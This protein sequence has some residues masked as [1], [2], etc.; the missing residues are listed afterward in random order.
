MICVSP[1]LVTHAKKT[2]PHYMLAASIWWEI[3]PLEIWNKALACFGVHKSTVQSV[4]ELDWPIAQYSRVSSLNRGDLMVG[5]HFVKQ[6][7]DIWNSSFVWVSL[8][9][10][11]Y[12]QSLSISS[13]VYPAHRSTCSP[14]WEN[15]RLWI[16]G[17]LLPTK[18]YFSCGVTIS[19]MT[20]LR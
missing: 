19:T 11:P 9:F 8:T 13:P 18:P 20:K 17:L 5:H 15:T 7:K 1:L 2:D 6:S 16:T 14:S 12:V 10:F 3:L 4:I